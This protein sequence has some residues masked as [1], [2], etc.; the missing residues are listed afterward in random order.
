MLC[1]LLDSNIVKI[2]NN[3]INIRYFYGIS[4]R[5]YTDMESI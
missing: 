1:G 2:P 4:T 5:S 3:E